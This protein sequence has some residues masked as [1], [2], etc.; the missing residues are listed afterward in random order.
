[1][2]LFI[3]YL[4]RHPQMHH[5][6]HHQHHRRYHQVVHLDLEAE[7]GNDIYNIMVIIF[8]LDMTIVEKKGDISPYVHQHPHLFQSSISAINYDIVNYINNVD[9][10]HQC[11]SGR[12]K[13]HHVILVHQDMSVIHCRYAHPPQRPHRSPIEPFEIGYESEDEFGNSPHISSRSSDASTEMLQE[14]SPFPMASQ[15][16]QHLRGH[17]HHLHQLEEKAPHILQPVVDIINICIVEQTLNQ[18]DH[19]H[20][21]GDNLLHPLRHLHHRAQHLPTH[22]CFF[23]STSRRSNQPFDLDIIVIKE[24]EVDIIKK[25]DR[26]VIIIQVI[27]TTVQE[28][29]GNSSHIMSDY[30]QSIDFKRCIIASEFIMDKNICVMFIYLQS[31]FT[32]ELIIPLK[33]IL[34]KITQVGFDITLIIEN[35]R[36]RQHKCISN[37]VDFININEKE[38]FPHLEEE[39]H[40]YL[41]ENIMKHMPNISHYSEEPSSSFLNDFITSEGIRG[42]HLRAYI[43]KVI[44][45]S[46][47][48]LDVFNTLEHFAQRG[49]Q[50]STI[51]KLDSIIEYQLLDFTSISGPDFFSVPSAINIDIMVIMEKLIEVMHLWYTY[52]I[53]I[54]D[55]ND[56]I[57]SES[58]AEYHLLDYTSI[59]RL[60]Y[61]AP[62]CVKAELINKDIFA[63]YH[64]LDYICI[65]GPNHISVNRVINLDINIKAERFIR[66]ICPS[67]INLLIN[68]Y[69]V[70]TCLSHPNG[71]IS[72]IDYDFNISYINFHIV[73]KKKKFIRVIFMPYINLS[74][75][76]LDLI[77]EAERFIRNHRY[78]YLVKNINRE[79]SS[80]VHNN[81]GKFIRTDSII[82]ESID[83][84]IPYVH[85]HPHLF[86]HGASSMNTSG[87]HIISVQY[88]MVNQEDSILTIPC[89]FI[90][91]YFILS[92]FIIDNYFHII[93]ITLH[94][95]E[96]LDITHSCPSGNRARRFHRIEWNK[97]NHLIIFKNID[98][99]N[100]THQESDSLIKHH[101]IG[102]KKGRIVN[103]DIAADL[104]SRITIKDLS[105]IDTIIYDTITHHIDI[106]DSFGTIIV[107]DIDLTSVM[108]EYILIMLIDFM[109][110]T[111]VDIDLISSEDIIVL[112]NVIIEKEDIISWTDI[113][114]NLDIQSFII[115][116]NLNNHQHFT[117]IRQRDSVILNYLILTNIYDTYH[118]LISYIDIS[119]NNLTMVGIMDHH[120]D[121]TI[122]NPVISIQLCEPSQLNIIHFIDIASN[123]YYGLEF[124]I[125][126]FIIHLESYITY[127]LKAY[128][129]LGITLVIIYLNQLILEPYY[130]I[131]ETEI[132]RNVDS[133]ETSYL[134]I[135]TSEF[136][137]TVSDMIIS[138]YPIINVGKEI[139][140]IEGTRVII[141]VEAKTNIVI[142]QIDS[143]F[144]KEETS[145][146]GG[147]R[148]SLQRLTS[149]R[150]KGDIQAHPC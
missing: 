45:K 50:S 101:Y 76:N 122:V 39:H 70:E 116:H 60:N 142:V 63:E 15:P 144:I 32:K 110:Q 117:N 29:P 25:N 120:F 79:V 102:A 69:K 113:V 103:H 7:R 135:S 121:Q 100:I 61:S 40:I 95:W 80:E 104:S 138:V 84:S 98:Y 44:I 115:K 125:E 17:L 88:P 23:L 57:R 148:T 143:V 33:I 87:K 146:S 42:S 18:R 53:Y 137:I 46:D 8:K 134:D 96:A 93:L 82:L 13:D 20:P 141:A 30:H 9:H 71:D 1:M 51:I 75:N 2:F 83:E 86:H 36:R 6:S 12:L 68:T 58:S 22:Q 91:K 67:H 149:L 81:Y 128:F 126:H 21:A 14:E 64:L 108:K 77:I 5:S 55:M 66:T 37:I 133:D 43:K 114:N 49:H 124:H 65:N 140:S 62:I 105:I 31:C 150:K 74:Y 118:L 106:Y 119:N 94:Q 59:S 89:V 11:I 131:I 139:N 41:E 130:T 16:P 109:K 52:H 47:I 24:E 147:H 54:F 112:D 26:E 90:S 38:Y 127:H 145:S 56:I 136:Y 99:R 97:T 34:E 111:S 48:I 85:Q 129:T 107:D 132:I 3:L 92:E 35:C 73:I 4:S 72:H 28:H 78:V 19:H 10:I 27:K 123:I